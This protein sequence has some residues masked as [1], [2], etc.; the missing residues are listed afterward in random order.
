MTR[1]AAASWLSDAAALL[2]CAICI[3]AG[4]LL[5]WLAT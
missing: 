2:A 4:M 1:F 3:T 5:A